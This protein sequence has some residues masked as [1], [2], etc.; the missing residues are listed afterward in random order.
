MKNIV[1]IVLIILSIGCTEQTEEWKM[2]KDIHS[3]AN[4]DEITVRHI[5][6]DLRVDFAVKQINGKVTLQ[7]EHKKPA[8]HLILDSRDLTIEKVT[9]GP[10]EMP[11]EFSLDREIPFLGQAL[12]IKID[13]TTT[14]VHVYYATSPDAEALQW[15]SP[16]QTAGKKHPFLFTQSQAIL[17]RTWVPCQDSPGIRMTYKA[18]V[19]VPRELMAVMSASNPTEK[20]GDGIYH[21]EMPQAIPSYL[22][23]LAVGDLE[24]RNL[25]SRSGVYAEP[26]MIEKS[27]YEF[28]DTEKMIEAAEKLYGPYRWGRYDLIVLPPSFPFGGME[29]PRLTFATPTILA[30][31]RSL[32]ALVA[33]ELAHSWSGNLVTNATWNDFWLNEGFTTYFERRI[34]E[35]VYGRPYSE[36]E[37]LLAMQDLKNEIEELGA[38]SPDTHLRLDLSGRNPDDG[39]T[40]VA[41]EKGYFFLRLCEETFG[42]QEWD[43][44][45]KGYFDKFAFQTMTTTHFLAYLDAQLIKGNEDVKKKLNVDAWVYGPG[46]PPNVPK[47]KSDALERVEGQAV[48]WA[49]NV[50]AAMLQTQ[51][52]TTQQWIHF[53]RKLPDSLTTKDMNDL[54]NTF[55]F[56]KSGNSEIQFAWFLHVIKNRYVAAY[57]ALK[58]FLIEVGRRKFVKPLFAKLAETKEGLKLANEIYT[59]ARPGY[60]SVTVSTVDDILGWGK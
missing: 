39:M 37:A 56:T 20:S 12:K 38:N 25:G 21:F 34:G 26:P 53:L 42:R 59:K 29:N 50:P 22:L 23:A 2:E 15:L 4:S 1:G 55:S 18:Q 8:T 16:A 48:A 28:A 13:S 52:W 51:G 27:V 11:T 54:D 10:D 43:R 60:H 49:N 45:L 57:P 46:I 40:D 58:R 44:F 19:S 35:A 6:L 36:M 30:G 17:A 41:Y 5:D 3:L 32:V 9:V 33:H 24:F 31:D 47:P 7:V 14:E